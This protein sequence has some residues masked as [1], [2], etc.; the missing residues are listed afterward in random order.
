MSSILDYVWSAGQYDKDSAVW[1]WATNFQLFYYTN[2]KANV[3]PNTGSGFRVA[4]Y[5]ALRP[6]WQSVSMSNSYRFICEVGF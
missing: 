4:L 6:N 2:W 1:Y 5:K 3:N